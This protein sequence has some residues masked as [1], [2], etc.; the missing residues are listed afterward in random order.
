MYLLLTRDLLF[1]KYNRV[2]E[3]YMSQS[4]HGTLKTDLRIKYWNVTFQQTDTFRC[5]YIISRATS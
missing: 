2:L 3:C 4:Y 1:Q 5:T